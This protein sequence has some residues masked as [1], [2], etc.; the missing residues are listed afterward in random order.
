MRTAAY[1]LQV[2]PLSALIIGALG[3][4]NPREVT[5]PAEHTAPSLMGGRD[6]RRPCQGLFAP[7]PGGKEKAGLPSSR[8]HEAQA[9]LWPR[10]HSSP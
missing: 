7:L 2:P 10:P 1:S 4:I 3:P 8:V 5:L 9:K 6:G